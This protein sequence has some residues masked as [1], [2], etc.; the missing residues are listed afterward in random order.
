MNIQDLIKEASNKSSTFKFKYEYWT[1][2][3]GKQPSLDW[4]MNL[5]EDALGK[6][7]VRKAAQTYIDKQEVTNG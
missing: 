2:T 6:S 3:R 5:L 7:Y 4:L 1:V